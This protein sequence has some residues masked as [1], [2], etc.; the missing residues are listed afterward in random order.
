MAEAYILITVEAGKARDVY[1]EL[2]KIKEI[3]HV[4]AIAGPFDIIA[5]VK[6][7][8]FNTIGRL[9]IEKIQN[10]PGVERTLTCNIIHFEQ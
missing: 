1:E 2:S 9:V 6:A 8:D 4:D 7:P 5:L 10:I 3:T